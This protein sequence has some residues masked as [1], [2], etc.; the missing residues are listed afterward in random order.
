MNAQK[1]E[2]IQIEL[3]ISEGY[4]RTMNTLIEHNKPEIL[5]YYHVAYFIP[6]LSTWLKA[7]KKETF[8]H[9]QD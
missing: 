1:L 2:Y 9:V 5:R 7:I 3:N 8:H 6:V 4:F